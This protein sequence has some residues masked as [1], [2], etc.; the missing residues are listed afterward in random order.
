MRASQAGQLFRN[1]DLAETLFRIANT[2]CRCVPIPVACY[3]CLSC[4]KHLDE[5][6]NKV[7]PD[8]ISLHAVLPSRYE[9]SCLAPYQGHG[10]QRHGN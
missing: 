1:P 5:C 2:N 3:P 9:F 8:L 6:M 10:N 4:S 7:E